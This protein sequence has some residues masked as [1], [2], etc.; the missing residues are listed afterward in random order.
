MSDAQSAVRDRPPAAVVV[1]QVALA[2]DLT[3][4]CRMLRVDRRVLL[5]V[6]TDEADPAL[7]LNLPDLGVDDVFGPPHDFDLVAARIH[8]PDAVYD[9]L[10]WEDDGEFSVHQVSVV[11]E[12]N[13]DESVESLL[14]EGVRILDESR[15]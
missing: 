13:I 3:R 4:V 10:A 8:R 14:M 12:Q 2:S 6:L 9:V 1:D 15:P 11:P 5:F 7:V